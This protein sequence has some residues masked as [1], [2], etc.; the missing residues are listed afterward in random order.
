MAS[1]CWVL[2]WVCT[3]VEAYCN[4]RWNR[5]TKLSSALRC[6][7][8]RCV[9]EQR[10]EC[11]CQPNGPYINVVCV[12]ICLFLD[13]SFR[14]FSVLC[15]HWLLF[16]RTYFWSVL[17]TRLYSGLIV[18]C[19]Q[20]FLFLGGGGNWRVVACL[21]QWLCAWTSKSSGIHRVGRYIITDI[22]GVPAVS[23]FRVCLVSSRTAQA[24]R[25]E[26][27]NPSETSVTVY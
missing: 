11:Q 10:Y 24:M 13:L 20:F 27:G 8:L 14:I 12:N 18:N 25:M 3:R 1:C 9:L 19:V 6:V 16:L 15:C 5:F 21:L 4:T 22:L 26:T 7:A 17:F 23:G 2:S